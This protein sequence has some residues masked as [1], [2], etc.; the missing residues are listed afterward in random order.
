MSK[1]F[2][3]DIVSHVD[4]QEIDNAVN[5]ARKEIAQRFDFKGT[6]SRIDFTRDEKLLVLVADDDMKL[7]NLRDILAMRLAKRGVSLKALEYGPL[8]DA[9][10]GT[11]RQEIRIISGI[12][13]EK[14]KA[15]IRDI[16][17]LR[18]KVQ[19]T[20]QGEQIRVSGRK[21]DELQEVIKTLRG[22]NYSIPLQ[23]VNFR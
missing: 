7:R 9:A 14:A 4:L 15:I 16:K 2:S 21:K 13:H 5:Q 10:E 20:L 11:L 6:K 1:D 18:L 8:A 12:E 3:F 17:E 23:F 19:S 22:K